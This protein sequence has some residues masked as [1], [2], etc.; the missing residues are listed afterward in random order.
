PS[1]WDNSTVPYGKAW[2]MVKFPDQR[3][4]SFPENIF[5]RELKNTDEEKHVKTDES[6]D[7]NIDISGD[8]PQGDDDEMFSDNTAHHTSS[9]PV[10]S[11]HSPT[12]NTQH[13][14][15]QAKAKK[16]MQ[17]AKKIIRKIN[18]KK[19]AIAHYVKARLT[20]SMREVKRNNHI[21]LFTKPSTSADDLLEID[22]KIKLLN[23]IHLNKS[24]PTHP[25]Q[26]P[27][28][29]S[30]AKK[31]KELIQK[32]E[33]AIA[34][35]EGI[36]LEKLKQQYKN[37]VKLESHVDQLKAVVLS[38][39]QW[40]SDEEKY[41]TSLIKCYAA[42]YHIQ[43]VKIYQKSLN[44]TNPK[45]YFKRTKD[46]IPYTM[47][48]A[49]KGII[50]DNLIEMVKK[51][52]MGRGNKRLKGRDWNEKNIKR[53]TK[54]LDKTDQVMKH[55]LEKLKQ[56]YKKDV[57]LKYH[58]DQLKA[59]VSIEARW[60]TGEGDVSKLRSFETHMSKSIKPYSSFYNNDF[61]YMVYHS[62]E[63]KYTTSLL[64]HYAARYH[65]QGIEDMISERWSKEV[66]RY[67]IKALNGIHH[68]EDGRQDFFKAEISNIS[69][70]KVYS[71]KRIIYVVRVVV[72]RK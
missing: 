19:K 24:N 70:G 68:W 4:L 27:S 41:T 21:S 62:T 28:T 22:L 35:L 67:Q 34:D 10:N 11:T 51:N 16:H 45:F 2:A 39:A 5:R 55:R 42:R 32:D 50:Q 13:N 61:Y 54:M 57:E 25:T 6:D 47:S 15:I 48:G 9:P 72:K 44:L 60:I 66:H 36:G 7:T 26:R 52:E 64:K 1:G 12:A 63:E 59:T 20:T 17:K 30:I 29:M 40:N 71:Y 14:S 23:I 31:L 56:Q 38:E 18:F 49:E 3:V 53:S 37:D 8:G 46:R 58:I 33:L 65:N 69:P 43:G